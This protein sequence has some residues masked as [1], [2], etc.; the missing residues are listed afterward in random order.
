MMWMMRTLLPANASKPSIQ[1]PFGLV[2]SHSVLIVLLLGLT[3]ASVGSYL[4]HRIIQRD[5]QQRF[6]MAKQETVDLVRARFDRFLSVLLHTRAFFTTKDRVS[7]QDFRIFLQSVDLPRAYPDLFGVGYADRI[8]PAHRAAHEREVRED[9]YYR[10]KVWPRHDG[11]GPLYP[12]KFL[13]PFDSFNQ[14]VLGFDLHSEAHRGRAMDRARESGDPTLTEPVTMFRD[15]EQPQPGFIL[16]LPVYRRGMSLRTP[17][18]RG[19]ALEGFLYAPFRGSD[20]FQELVRSSPIFHEGIGVRATVGGEVMF[21]SGLPH[22]GKLGSVTTVPLFGQRWQ[23]EVYTTHG[24]ASPADRAAPL[25]VFIAGVLI[26]ILASG[27]VYVTGR[28]SESQ[29]EAI[30]MRDEFLSICSHELRTPLTSMKLQNQLVQRTLHVDLARGNTARFEKMVQQSGRQIDRLVRLVEE[31]LDISRIRSGKLSITPEDVDFA[32][33][34]RETVERFAPQLQE[35]GCVPHLN[36]PDELHGRW[37]RMRLEQVVA[38][39]LSNAIKYGSGSPIHLK[40]SRTG[41]RAFLSV[42]DEGIGIAPEHQARIFERFERAVAKAEISGLGLGLYIAR[43]ILELQGGSIR[44]E[45]RPGKGSCFTVDLPI[46]AEFGSDMAREPEAR[47]VSA[48]IS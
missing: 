33:L 48:E 2:V 26:T 25:F 30:E 35:A 8:A 11:A 20:V 16:F 9:G 10:Y 12:I 14:N 21:A 42:R 41:N 37:D 47:P 23:L 17:R 3:T 4:A 7:R 46:S 27:V 24:F 31:M 6:E 15:R 28:H 36:L 18:E 22:E 34:V 40:L 45:S 43:Q 19:W 38:N 13:E 29:R 5:Q 39:L 32:E 1:G 44:V